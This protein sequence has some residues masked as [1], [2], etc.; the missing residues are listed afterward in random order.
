[1]FTYVTARDSLA[2]LFDS[3]TAILTSEYRRLLGDSRTLAN[4]RYEWGPIVA[5]LAVA[6]ILL[7]MASALL[8]H[9][10]RSIKKDW[11]AVRDI[12]HRLHWQ[13]DDCQRLHK[14]R[15]PLKD[16]AMIRS[17]RRSKGSSPRDMRYRL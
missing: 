17:C 16:P 4:Y 13:L 11:R 7:L 15:R 1:M 12:N 2:L 14:S 8:Y 3:R 9:E 6:C 10:N 5:Y